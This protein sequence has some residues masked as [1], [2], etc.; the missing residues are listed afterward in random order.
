M[1]DK[2]SQNSKRAIP[3]PTKMGNAIDKVLAK[4]PL[5][6]IKIVL[7]ALAIISTIVGLG[8]FIYSITRN[9]TSANVLSIND[10]IVTVQIGEYNNDPI[11]TDIKIDEQF[12]Y[13][14]GDSIYIDKDNKSIYYNLTP[15]K[16]NK[17]N[18]VGCVL[19]ITPFLIYFSIVFIIMTVLFLFFILIV[20]PKT[21]IKKNKLYIIP[22]ACTVLGLIMLCTFASS[23]YANTWIAIGDSLILIPSTVACILSIKKPKK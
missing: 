15:E 3:L 10:N 5:Q 6:S 9:I 18:F 23:E 12:N 22:I 2:M 19:M 4:I 1:G 13:Q 14:V 16:I 11:V 17:I 8:L 20:L 7:F 21:L